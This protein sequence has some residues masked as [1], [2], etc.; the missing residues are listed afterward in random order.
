MTV[1]ISALAARKKF[2]TLIDKSYYLNQCTVVKRAN[3][4][5]AA[6]VPVKLLETIEAYGDNLMDKLLSEM[7]KN[8]LSTKEA[9]NLANDAKKWSRK[10]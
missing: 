9:M 3:K 6:I 1:D 7:K 4:P 10:K 2:G 5:M 8:K